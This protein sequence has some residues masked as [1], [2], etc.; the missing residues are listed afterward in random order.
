[1]KGRERSGSNK[2]YSPIYYLK[3]SNVVSGLENTRR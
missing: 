3:K 1:M 2:G